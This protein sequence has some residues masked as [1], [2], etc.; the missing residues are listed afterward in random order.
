MLQL[1][2]KRL[3]SD[4]LQQTHVK[5]NKPSKPSKRLSLEVTQ[6]KSDL[7][8]SQKLR[9]D[10]YKEEFGFVQ[11][12]AV[13]GLDEDIY[14]RV[15][16]HLLVKD[17]STG[18]VVGGYRLLTGKNA[19]KVGGFYADEEFDLVQLSSKR[20]KILEIGRACIHP[21]FRTGA[22]L[23][24]LWS[25][26]VNYALDHACDLIIG[27]ASVSLKDGG[28]AATAV[29]KRTLED[30]DNDVPFTVRPRNPLPIE[31][32]EAQLPSSVPPLIRGYLRAGAKIT[33]APTWDPEF[34]TADFFTCLPLAAVEGRY[35]RHFVDR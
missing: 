19:Q 28:A 27:S 16:D 33:G 8:Q 2:L 10:V 4:M 24:M 14:D 18:S 1:I 26:I 9:Y 17:T 11:Q 22:T 6:D 13:S 12:S 23:A 29:Y 32:L 15:C 7:R 3:C 25:G 20:E 30:R 31:F 21:D 35:A 34:N 5:P